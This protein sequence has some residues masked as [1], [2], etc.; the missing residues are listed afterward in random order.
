MKA[1][2][3]SQTDDISY[4]PLSPEEEKNLFR[5]FYDNPAMSDR[6]LAARDVLIRKH[7]KLA[8][9]LSLQAAK[10]VLREE[11]AISAGNM[12]LIQ[13][14]ESRKFDTKYGTRFSTYC[15][16]YITGQTFRAL[17]F[18]CIAPRYTDEE[19]YSSE[20]TITGSRAPTVGGVLYGAHNLLCFD[21]RSSP[22]GTL[23]TVDHG[24]EELELQ[25]RRAEL[26]SE[27]LLTLPALEAAAVRGE[28]FAQHTFAD[29]ARAHG[30]TR[31]GVRKAYSRGMKKITEALINV[32]LEALV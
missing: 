3:Y 11:D 5:E 8:A 14:L 16:R 24:Y 22:D 20:A 21:L 9:K 28:F 12:G 26:I 15:R 13:A 6:S 23:S 2:Y 29:T 25:E 19:N 7:L 17:R 10:G 32:K 18:L 30:V 4:V 1:Q 31:E 27:V